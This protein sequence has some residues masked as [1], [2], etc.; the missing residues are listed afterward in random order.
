MKAVIWG[1]GDN[2]ES[3]VVIF[4]GAVVVAMV[5]GQELKAV[6]LFYSQL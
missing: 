6:F 3:M 2:G 4:R 5:I 1:C